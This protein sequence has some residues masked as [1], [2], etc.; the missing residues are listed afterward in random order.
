MKGQ[1]CNITHPVAV[2]SMAPFWE[3]LKKSTGKLLI[4]E[5]KK[6][7]TKYRPC[8]LSSLK[9]IFTDLEL[10]KQLH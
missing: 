6:I 2:L 8:I 3:E 10:L 5:K 4:E 7:S 9:F 1:F